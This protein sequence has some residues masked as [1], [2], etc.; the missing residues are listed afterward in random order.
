MSA[1]I[2]YLSA[3]PKRDATR[4]QLLE[5]GNAL[6]HQGWTDAAL[7]NWLDRLNGWEAQSG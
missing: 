6:L 7:V 4:D 1:T 3:K 5:H 2:Y